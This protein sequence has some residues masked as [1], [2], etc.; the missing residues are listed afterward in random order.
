MTEN[1]PIRLVHVPNETKEFDKCLAVVNI[2]LRTGGG[3]I[4]TADNVELIMNYTAQWGTFIQ[5]GEDRY[6]FAYESHGTGR[7][8]FSSGEIITVKLAYCGVDATSL[9]DDF[10]GGFGHGS[11]KDE[12]GDLAFLSINWPSDDSKG[13]LKIIGGTGKW[14][15]ADGQLDLDIQSRD[16]PGYEFPPKS[17]I[18]SSAVV[19]GRGQITAPNRVPSSK[20]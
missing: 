2:S 19:H 10:I 15:G 20:T 9:D 4:R 1:I 16:H 11:Q 7:Y 6:D 3:M 17:P 18:T 13:Q 5:T 14:V 12:D 8:T